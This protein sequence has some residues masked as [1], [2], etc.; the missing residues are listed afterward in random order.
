ML[1]RRMLQRSQVLYTASP[2]AQ[3][4]LSTSSTRCVTVLPDNTP[5]PLRERSGR[6]RMNKVL[7]A[8]LVDP[9]T[10]PAREYA[11]I[12]VECESL[13]EWCVHE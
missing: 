12:G 4:R 8:F 5:T 7:A 9:P 1:E 10:D 3:L 11:P 6:D 2:K 13:G